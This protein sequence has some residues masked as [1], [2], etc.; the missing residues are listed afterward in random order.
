MRLSLLASA[1]RLPCSSA[2]IVAGRPG[3]ADDRVEHDVGLGV[4]GELGERVAVVA[5][6]ARAHFGSTPNSAACC[7][8]QL[9]VA[10]G[11]ERDD[12]VVVA[13]TADDVERLGADRAGRPQ[14]RDAVS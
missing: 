10:A 14:D 2:A 5:R 6:S 11:G 9:G 4:R 13:V 1:R 8:E 7:V 3:E 12:L